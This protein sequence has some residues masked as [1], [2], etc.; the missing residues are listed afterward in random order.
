MLLGILW[1]GKIFNNEEKDDKSLLI[2]VK[3][4]SMKFCSFQPTEKKH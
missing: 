4:I 2:V 3:N 1:L